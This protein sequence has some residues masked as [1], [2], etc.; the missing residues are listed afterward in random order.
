MLILELS[1]TTVL[2]LGTVKLFNIC[3]YKNAS[4][5]SRALLSFRI[6]GGLLLTHTLVIPHTKAVI[7]IPITLDSSVNRSMGIP[8]DLLV[9]QVTTSQ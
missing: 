2:K 1:L 6:K 3:I 5:N 8:I 9:E 7:G 4:R